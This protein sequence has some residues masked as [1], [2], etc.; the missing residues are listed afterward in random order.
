MR[1]MF[2]SDNRN[3]VV[4]RDIEGGLEGI[5]FRKSLGV[6]GDR[7]IRDQVIGN[8]EAK[9]LKILPGDLAIQLI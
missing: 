7:N 3:V 4:V 1:P 2:G 6:F 8:S 9:S 5:G